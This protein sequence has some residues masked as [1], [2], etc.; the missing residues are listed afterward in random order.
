MKILVWLVIVLA[1]LGGGWYYFTQMDQAPAQPTGSAGIN[2]SNDQG[3]MG[4]AGTGTVQ[5]PMSDGAEGVV[6]GSNLALGTDGEAGIGTYLIGYTGAPVYTKDGDTATTSTCYDTCA[7]NW[8]PYI[9]GAEDNV[10]Q[11]KSGVDA[12]K[13]GTIIRTDGS[14]QMTYNGKPLYFYAADANASGPKGDGVN[15]VWH[16]AKP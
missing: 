3:N 14:I 10:T 4:G 7:K 15:G 1:L 8:P 2:G 9:V 16:V 5:L 6:I 12:S 13:T 11:V